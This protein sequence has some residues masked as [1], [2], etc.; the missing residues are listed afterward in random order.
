ML[1]FEDRYSRQRRLPE[2]GQAGQQ[3]VAEA[4]FA[5]SAR[6]P[7]AWLE[8]LYLHRA[9]AQRV[10]LSTTTVEGPFTHHSAFAFDQTRQVAVGAHRALQKLRTL[11][12]VSS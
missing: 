3:Q 10:H 1:P 12:G 2:V 7:A 9:G 6:D 11:L 4:A 8:A 5:V